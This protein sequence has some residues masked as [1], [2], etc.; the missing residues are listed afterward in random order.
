[1]SVTKYRSIEEMPPVWHPIGAP[2]LF[3]AIRAVWAFADRT[4]P[5]RFPPGV[6][7]YRSIED[8]QRE[9]E[10]WAEANFRAHWD[11]QAATR[12]AATDRPPRMGS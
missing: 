1:M 11:R 2:A 4:C 8:A 3:R 12:V 5:R 7:K 10:R 6:T 9:R